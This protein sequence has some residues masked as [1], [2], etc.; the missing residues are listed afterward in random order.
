MPF[1]I[2]SQN[3]FGIVEVSLWF[4]GIVSGGKS[5]PLDKEGVASSLLP[6]G[7]YG[8]NFVL[9]FS[10]NEVRRWSCV[11]GSVNVVFFVGG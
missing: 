8:F 3:L 4:P 5:F 7:D 1:F 10:F 11:I 9:V 2:V 6:V